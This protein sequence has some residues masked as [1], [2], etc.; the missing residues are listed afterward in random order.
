MRKLPR[1][2]FIAVSGLALAYAA[3]VE[4]RRATPGAYAPQPSTPDTP[5]ISVTHSI[6]P[7]SQ[8]LTPAK[9]IAMAP[10][11]L[12]NDQASVHVEDP[13]SR[14]VEKL[15]LSPVPVVER[16]PG[17][18][19]RQ[20]VS[21]RVE[22]GAQPSKTTAWQNG[23]QTDTGLIQMNHGRIAHRALPQRP[24]VIANNHARFAR[25]GGPHGGQAIAMV[26]M[27]EAPRGTG[28]KAKLLEPFRRLKAWWKRSSGHSDS[29]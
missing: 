7:I 5:N 20:A 23:N 2:A 13:T 8:A 25:V 18:Y 4:M 14:A 11:N 22:P 28:L 16:N 27:D 21:G 9:P 1:I 10:T 24:V 15:L 19:Q 29:M 3:T 17:T 12:P 6:A 26:P